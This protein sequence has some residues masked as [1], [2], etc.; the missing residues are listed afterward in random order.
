MKSKKYLSTSK[1][2][3]ELEAAWLAHKKIGPVVAED[4]KKLVKMRNEVAKELG[5][6]N[7]HEMK[8]KLSEQDPAEILKLFDELDI[9]NERC[10]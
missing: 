5:Y 1:D 6:L 8:L 10:F 2:S 4:V 9:L 3:K 7:F